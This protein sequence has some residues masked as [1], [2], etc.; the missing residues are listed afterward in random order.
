MNGI[1]R[2]NDY[3]PVH[4]ENDYGKQDLFYFQPEQPLSRDDAARYIARAVELTESGPLEFA[5]A[6]EIAD[7]EETAQT[8]AAGVLK[9]FEDNTFRPNATTT[10]AETAVIMTRIV[11]YV[12]ETPLRKK[13]FETLP[14]RITEIRRQASGEVQISV[15]ELQPCLIKRAEWDALQSGDRYA[16][17]GEEYIVYI[18]DDWLKGLHWATSDSDVSNISVGVKDFDEENYAFV[19]W[20]NG[21]PIIYEET[22][23][24]REFTLSDDFSYFYRDGEGGANWREYYDEMAFVEKSEA[25]TGDGTGENRVVLQRVHRHHLEQRLRGLGGNPRRYGSGD[26][27]A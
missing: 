11:K 25:F 20:V 26:R 9:G 17:R 10:R 22:D 7:K 14:C 16:F 12:Q 8:V 23:N 15:A 5:D 18:G 24:P 1:V 27:S 13:I 3:T 4:Q 21:E 6:S 19:G 2:Y